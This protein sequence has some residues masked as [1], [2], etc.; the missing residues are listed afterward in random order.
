M[1]FFLVLVVIWAVM[2]VFPFT[3]GFMS[4][5]TG[6]EEIPLEVKSNNTRDPRYF[7]KSFRALVDK[8]L[9][10]RNGDT[11]MLSKQEKFLDGDLIK[12]CLLYTSQGQGI[13]A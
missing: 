10:S 2:M 9:L 4:Q 12:G 1:I 13:R 11:I 3:L 5:H 6:V 8:A 7:A